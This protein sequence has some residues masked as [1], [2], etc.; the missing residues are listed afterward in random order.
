M[1]LLVN[2]IHFYMAVACGL[3]SETAID[4]PKMSSLEAYAM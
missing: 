1:N 4:C 3:N 2:S